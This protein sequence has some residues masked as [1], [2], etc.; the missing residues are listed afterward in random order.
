MSEPPSRDERYSLSKYETNDLF[1]WLE[2][3]RVP[4]ADF[5]LT[6]SDVNVRYHTQIMG[7]KLPTMGRLPVTAI[8]HPETRSAF[9]IRKAAPDSFEWQ[10]ATSWDITNQQLFDRDSRYR[11]YST[12]KGVEESFRSWAGRVEERHEALKREKEEKEKH[13]QTRDFW[14]ELKRSKEF[15]GREPGAGLENTQF[16]EAEQGEISAQMK[17][18]EDY[19][20]ATHE[21]TSEQITQ[22]KDRLDHAE[23]AS[24][25][26]GRKDWIVLFNGAVFSLILTD[27]I[28]P[29][30]A[31]H[32]ILM[33]L[34]GIGHLFGIGGPPPHLPPGG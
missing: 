8:R 1:R 13:Y 6:V 17:R 22:V 3:G 30:T 19:I 4:I 20:K 14:E 24:K 28:T 9:A 12:W 21:L 2:S 10:D 15:S 27:L 23:E 25:R 26:M 31:Q 32:I 18:I 5:E 29:P 16:S 33:I 7:M 11:K 34:H